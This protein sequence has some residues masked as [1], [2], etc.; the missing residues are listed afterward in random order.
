MTVGETDRD[1]AGAGAARGLRRRHAG[2]RWPGPEL[3]GRP[4]AG[5]RSRRRPGRSTTPRARR[6]PETDPEPDPGTDVREDPDRQPRRDRLPGH[7]DGPAHGHPHGRGLFRRR[8]AGAARAHGRRGGAHRPRA[9]GAVLHRH[10]ADPRGGARPPAPRRCIRATAFSASAPNSPRR[11]RRRASPSSARR[12]GRSR[13][14][15][16]RSPRRSWPRR[17]GVSTVPG[18]MGLIDDA[19]ARGEDRRARSAIR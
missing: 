13:R 6:S 14:W 12:S 15:A 11:W 17:P 8:R 7:Q 1:A 9:G 5:A 4:D 3:A 18:H 2:R 19:G 10:R 16:T